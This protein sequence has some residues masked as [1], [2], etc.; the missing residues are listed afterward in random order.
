M[1]WT[2][3]CATPDPPPTDG[4]PPA[5]SSWWTPTTPTPTGSGTTSPTGT[6]GD[7][8]LPPA[9]T[10]YPPAP[11]DCAAGV[12]PGPLAFAGVAGIG[13]TEDLAFDTDGFL[14]GADPSDDLV[15]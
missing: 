6:T 14:V 9:G 3:A 12:P 15:R 13:I 1:W 10:L 11:Y 4:G 5:T 7:T 8:A 2:W